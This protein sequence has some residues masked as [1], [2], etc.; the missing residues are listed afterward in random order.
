M[1]EQFIEM[2]KIFFFCVFLLSFFTAK[3]CRSQSTDTVYETVRKPY[4]YAYFGAGVPTGVITITGGFSYIRT[5]GWGITGGNQYFGIKSRETPSDFYPGLTFFPFF[6]PMDQLSSYYVML[7]RDFQS[8]S[9]F[10]RFGAEAGPAI[11]RYHRL[12]FTKY[13]YPPFLGSNYAVATHK[14]INIGLTCRLRADLAFARTI[15]LQLVFVG[16]LNSDEPYLGGELNFNIGRVRERT[17]LEN[18]RRGRY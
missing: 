12:H 11:I 15:G 7:V 17:R 18:Q 1:N 13:E 8:P 6:Y 2:K 16:N 4:I 5:D 10:F 9:P 14:T 3:N